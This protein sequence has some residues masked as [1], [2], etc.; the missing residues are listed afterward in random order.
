MDSPAADDSAVRRGC[1]TEYLDAAEE[2]DTRYHGNYHYSPDQPCWG[3][4]DTTLPRPPPQQAKQAAKGPR[5]V[6]LEGGEALPPPE[7]PVGLW[8]E[9]METSQVRPREAGAAA[10]IKEEGGR[11][12]K[13]LQWTA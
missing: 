3:S 7:P 12:A 6:M 4:L 9:S 5:M 1:C 2:D 13:R 8:L 11:K 10:E